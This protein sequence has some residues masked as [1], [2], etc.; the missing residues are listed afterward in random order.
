M[1]KAILTGEHFFT[2][3]VACAEGALAAGCRFFGG[4]PITPATE[5]AERM[6][7][8]LPHVGGSY[9]Q[10]E[11]EIA[12]IA[13]VLGASWAG[14]KSMTATSGPGFSLMMENLGLGIC[15]E[16]PCV[17]V[18]VQRGGPST[19]LP[20]QG[21]QG[22]MM[23]SRWGS[24]GDY[25]IIV[26]APYSPQEIFYQT[27]TAFNLS[28]TYRIPVLIMTD[29]IVG[30][31]SEKVIIPDSRKVKTISRTAPKGR[32]DRFRLFEPGPNGVAPMPAAGQGYNVHVTGLTHDEKGYP[33]MTVDTQVEMMD[34]LTGK[35]RNNLDDIIMTESYMMDD[36]EI[37]LVS[38]GV[39]ARTCLA[40]VDQAR[41]SGIKAGMFRLITVWP[42]PEEEIKKIAERVKGFITVEMNLGQI[43]REVQRC[44]G[45]KVPAVLVGHHGGTIIPPEDV[46]KK[47]KETF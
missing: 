38:Y 11:D 17:I 29:E 15:T 26:L 23:Q 10:M 35:I 8:R 24:H 37:V 46:L 18:N 6:A 22:D 31:M 2:G 30:H 36:A 20:T 1:K 33:V 4:Y 16:T 42:F 47:M 14:V 44:V 21:A 7:S 40:A 39:S 45:G 28:E 5:I 13:S 3:D 9:I 34:R 43:H 19:G 32:K 27:I 41:K 25:E 12:A